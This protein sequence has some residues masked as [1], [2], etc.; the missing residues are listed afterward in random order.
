VIINQ[1]GLTSNEASVRSQRRVLL[2]WQGVAIGIRHQ[3]PAPR[4][5][6]WLQ[7]LMLKK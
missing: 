3:A 4:V 1:R 6:D 5:N 7:E 2:D